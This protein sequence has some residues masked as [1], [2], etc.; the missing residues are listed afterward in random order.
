VTPLVAP[1]AA[2]PA[3][4]EFPPRKASQ[5]ELSPLMAPRVRASLRPPTTPAL[6]EVVRNDVSH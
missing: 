3:G 6:V 2:L 4:V 5:G 1:G